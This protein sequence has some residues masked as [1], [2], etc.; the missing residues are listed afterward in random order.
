MDPI[1]LVAS[2]TA[3]A[4]AVALSSAAI[5]MSCELRNC[6]YEVFALPNELS[7]LQ[8]A[9]LQFPRLIQSLSHSVQLSQEIRNLLLHTGSRLLQTVELLKKL[10]ERLKKIKSLDGR[11]HQNF[12][13]R[14]HWQREQANIGQ[15]RNQIRETRLAMMLSLNGASMAR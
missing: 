4:D 9:L 8:F 12:I 11:F 3:A 10:V 7:D 15:R 5:K 6:P 14:R 2:S 1:S 13:S